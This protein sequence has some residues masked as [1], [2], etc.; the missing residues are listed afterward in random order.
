MTANKTLLQHKYA[1]VIEMYSKR[2][3]ASLRE[4]M[5]IFYKS[6]TYQLMREGISDMHCRSDEYLAEELSLELE[7][8]TNAE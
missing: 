1:N 8:K 4:S 3:N 2:Y 6:F 5:D 7:P